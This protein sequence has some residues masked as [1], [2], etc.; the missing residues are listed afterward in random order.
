MTS[1]L[2]QIVRKLLE[3]DGDLD[4]LSDNELT[5]R[6]K[7]DGDG[8]N[9]SI[10]G[11]V[12]RSLWTLQENVYRAAAQ[13]LHGE[14]NIKTLTSDERS[15][16]SLSFKVQKGC[17]DVFV[18]T[19]EAATEVAKGFREMN[20][21][22]KKSVFIVLI[23]CGLIGCTGVVAT[24]AIF[25]YL[26]RKSTDAAMIEQAKVLAD[27]IGKAIELSAQAIAKSSAGARSV[28]IGHS[29]RY[30]EEQIQQ[31]HRKADRQPATTDTYDASF[32]VQ[33]VELAGDKLRVTLVDESNGATLV[34]TLPG[35]DLFDEPLPHTATEVAKLIG[36]PKTAVRA[37]IL[38]R[39]TK[40]KVDRVIVSWSPFAR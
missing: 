11:E 13:I 4:A 21:E 27:P 34:A 39:E 17:T 28:Q 25:A 31:L 1:E 37:S 24:E 35:K 5:L 8:F 38:I 9:S 20:S 10:T 6:I 30:D 19:K 26:G 36:D 18:D 33:G 22:D 15:R 12:A 29:Y 7:I 3:S 40:T 32:T 23:V 16:L 2:D 14:P